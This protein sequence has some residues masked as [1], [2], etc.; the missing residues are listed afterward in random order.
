VGVSR[1]IRSLLN[2]QQ[3]RPRSRLCNQEVAKA[4][5]LGIVLQPRGCI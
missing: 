5:R 2:L 1:F 3:Q 4:G